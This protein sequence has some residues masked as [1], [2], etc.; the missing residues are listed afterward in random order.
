[1]MNRDA[2]FDAER[3]SAR[4]ATITDPSARPN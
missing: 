2:L 4:A 3:P 1:V